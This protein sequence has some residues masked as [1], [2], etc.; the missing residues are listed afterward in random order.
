MERGQSLSL[1]MFF[2]L[3]KNHRAEGTH[4]RTVVHA[5][6]HSLLFACRQKGAKRRLGRRTR[7]MRRAGTETSAQTLFAGKSLGS[8]LPRAHFFF[9]SFL[10]TV[11]R[12]HFPSASFFEL[13][14]E[15]F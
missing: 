14:E 13:G 3:E 8:L 4:T 2:L 5:A 11:A 7:G 12:E 6:A 10:E 9:P 1:A 15:A